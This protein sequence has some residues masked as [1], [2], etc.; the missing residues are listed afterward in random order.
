[1]ISR[2]VRFSFVA[3][4]SVFMFAAVQP[5]SVW[6]QDHVVSSTDLRKDV[7]QAAKA[8]QT[9]EARIDAFL[10]TPQAKKA[11]SAA[12][13]DYK[14]VENGVSLLNDKEVADLAARADKA[15]ADF[16]AGSLTNE[17]LTYIIIALATAVIILIIVYH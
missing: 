4:A 14:T 8:R 6:A 9:Q 15:Q 12:N 11:L 10:R 3:F 7:H 2:I 5:Q 1:M 16:A 13:I 17:Q